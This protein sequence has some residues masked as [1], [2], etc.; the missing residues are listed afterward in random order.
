MSKLNT[1]F[2]YSVRIGTSVGQYI[3]M[4]I[5]SQWSKTQKVL[6]DVMSK[7]VQAPTLH[8]SKLDHCFT[9]TNPFI[10]WKHLP[11]ITYIFCKNY[12]IW[13]AILWTPLVWCI[14]KT[15]TPLETP[16]SPKNTLRSVLFY[17]F[18]FIFW[19]VNP[20]NLWVV[21]SNIEVFEM[22]L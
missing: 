22:L 8:W 7:S 19:A 10:F 17:F 21:N 3:A 13:S 20:V 11:N 1:L 9:K 14:Y 5:F 15:S 18:K 6:I 2:T 16:I 12:N 4:I